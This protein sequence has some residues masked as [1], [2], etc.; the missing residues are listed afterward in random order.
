VD[1]PWITATQTGGDL[2]CNAVVP[3][4][5]TS[6]VV[7]SDDCGIASIEHHGDLTNV[8]GCVT[9]VTRTYRV[10]DGCANY[11][12]SVM[13]FT[14]RN[15]SVAP[16]IT[17]GPTFVPVIELGCNPIAAPAVDP[18]M[19]SVNDNCDATAVFWLNDSVVTNGF[20]A[21]VQR[22]YVADDL[23][24]NRASITQTYSYA[25]DNANPTPTIVPADIDL[26]CQADLSNVPSPETSL[27]A[28]ADMCSGTIT[29]TSHVDD[30]V[31]PQ[32]NYAKPSLA[33][34]TALALN[35][36]MAGMAHP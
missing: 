15:D 7:A 13:V 31:P 20:S 14:M 29:H 23:C 2:G 5:D 19:F 24:G 32:S 36:S 21:T 3:P 34:V 9:M 17:A 16:V 10:T 22:T 30:V 33:M 35:L 4:A 25:I 18:T 28:A 11:V 26:G 1:A 12:D 6:V 27:T 8:S